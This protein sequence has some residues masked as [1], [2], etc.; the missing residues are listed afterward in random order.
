[1]PF[2]LH[3]YAIT[4][5][6]KIPVQHIFYGETREEADQ[7]FNGHVAACPMFGPAEREGRMTTFFEEIDSL[8]TE[9]SVDDEAEEIVADD[10]EEE[11]IE[12]GEGG[13]W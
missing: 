10:P 1:M 2:A 12:E 11:E 8:P 3:A 6:K 13:W 7:H 5:D 4:K 9:E